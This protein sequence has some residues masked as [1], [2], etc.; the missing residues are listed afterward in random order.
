MRS[1]WSD[2]HRGNDIIYDIIV[3]GYIIYV[4]YISTKTNKNI[5]RLC[6]YVVC[7]MSIY[8]VTD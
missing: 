1:S 8:A 6:M 2:V 7:H 5:M 3:Y 4:M